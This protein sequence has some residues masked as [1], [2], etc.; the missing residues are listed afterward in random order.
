LFQAIF[1]YVLDS[2]RIAVKSAQVGFEDALE[3]FEL[4]I[5]GLQLR[6][7][8]SCDNTETGKSQENVRREND[9][10]RTKT[11]GAQKSVV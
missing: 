7:H 4:G 2:L 8:V 1:G 6:R 10:H 5:T 11:K 3:I 9:C